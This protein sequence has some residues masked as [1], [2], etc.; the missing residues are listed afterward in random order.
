MLRWNSR[1][2]KPGGRSGM[3]H[4]FGFLGAVGLVVWLAVWPAAEA[5]EYKLRVVSIP[6]TAYTSL[7]LPGEFTDGASG[8]GLNRLEA[9]LDSGEFPSGPVLFD[10]RVQ[11]VRD[12]VTPAYRGSR[13][14]PVFTAA[15]R[16]PPVPLPHHP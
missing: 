8:A 9:A 1:R 2:L 16:G 13:V 4:Q 10:R 12:S 6:D 5:V 3:R 7:L 14:L 15:G 11:P